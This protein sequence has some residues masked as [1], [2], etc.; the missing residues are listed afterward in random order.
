MNFFTRMS[1]GWKLAMTSIGFIRKHTLLVLFPVISA[2]CMIVLLGSF[3][4]VSMAIFGL[5]V[6]TAL[7]SDS[8]A[9]YIALFVIYLISYSIIVFFNMAMIFCIKKLFHDEKVTFV[10]GLKFGMSRFHQIFAWSAVSATVGVILRAIEDKNKFIASIVS[11]ILG[12]LWG[13]VTFF[14]LPILVY[15][16][17]GVFEAVKKSGALIRKTWGERVGAGFAFELIGILMYF[18]VMV[19]PIALLFMVSPLL[20]MLVAFLGIIIVS[21]IISAASTVFKTA[22]YEF[23]TEGENPVYTEDEMKN[24]FQAVDSVA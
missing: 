13:I 5:D 22:A 21:S 6:N 24:I 23:A 16:N 3:A 10:E 18:L 4:G 20:A 2:I 15:E 17:L 14:V 1:H 9:R 7:D 8:P 11:G 19:I 12:A